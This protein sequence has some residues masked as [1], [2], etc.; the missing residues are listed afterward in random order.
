VQQITE[1]TVEIAF[2]DQGYSGEQA[3]QDAAA[4][5]I[6]LEVVKLPEAKRGFVLLPRR[7]AMERGF[8]WTRRF[9][10]LARNYER[11]AEILVGSHLVPL[12]SS[13][14]DNLLS[15]QYKVHNTF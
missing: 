9:R 5:G 2:V 14:F 11:L 6:Q 1:E 4:E 12:P 7:W 15:F 10:R 8:A 13:C 3:A